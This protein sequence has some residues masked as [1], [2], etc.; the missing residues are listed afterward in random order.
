MKELLASVEFW[1]A[2]FLAVIL[3]LGSSPRISVR[4]AAIASCSAVAS[5]LIFTRPLVEMLGLSSETYTY[6]VAAL[7]ALTT[8]HIA[9]Q[10]LTLSLADAIAMWRGKK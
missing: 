4:S 8:E 10:I 2:M 6:A 5:A 7:V 9:R 3:K 1:I